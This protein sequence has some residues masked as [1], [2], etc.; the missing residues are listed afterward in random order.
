MSGVGRDR[1]VASGCI[2]AV[3]LEGPIYGSEPGSAAVTWRPI[4]TNA[5]PAERLDG[6][7]ANASTG[8]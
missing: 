6:A 2:G 4:A 5:S 8:P 7:L 3:C 1:P